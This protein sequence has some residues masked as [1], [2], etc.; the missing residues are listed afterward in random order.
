MPSSPRCRPAPV[1]AR[2]PNYPNFAEVICLQLDGMGI[3]SRLT[4]KWGLGEALRL[5]QHCLLG[6]ASCCIVAHR[7]GVD[8]PVWGMSEFVFCCQRAIPRNAPRP[9]FP[10]SR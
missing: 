8:C 10:R 9:K 7:V 4:K 5:M 1:V 2:R 6:V 3:P